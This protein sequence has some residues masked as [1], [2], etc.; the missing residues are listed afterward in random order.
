M[1]SACTSKTTPN[2]DDIVSTMVAE[3]LSAPKINYSIIN[4]ESG[5]STECII[6]VRLPDRISEDEVNRLAEHIKE[7]EGI[8][9]SPL[10]IYYFLPNDTPGKDTAW[11][12]SFFN[13]ELISKINC[14]DINTKATLEA[15]NP[16]DDSN[17]IGVWLYTGVLPYKIII[18]K[19]NSSYVMTTTFEDGSGTTQ[20]LTVKNVNDEERLY[21]NPDNFYGDY[22]VIRD[23]LNLAFYDNSGLIFELSP[24]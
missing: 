24:E 14:L 2:Q 5:Q 9:C 19:N 17:V 15:I 22:M 23:N 13:P 20:V 16:P 6:D 21:E 12:Y 18:S 11:A 4:K 1:S 7:N 10:Y 8:N 3:T